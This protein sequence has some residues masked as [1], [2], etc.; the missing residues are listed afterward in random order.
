MK[1]LLKTCL[2]LLLFALILLFPQLSFQYAANGLNLWF[3]RMVPT[4]MPFMIL[5]T[6]MIRQNLS[7]TFVSLV[8]PLFGRIYK[9]NK[10]G[11]YCLFLGFLC[12]FP[13][14][15]RT[16]AELYEKQDIS[17]K[18]ATFLLAFCN[19]IGPVYYISFLLPNTELFEPAKLPFLLFGMYGIPL[20]YGFFLSRT[21]VALPQNKSNTSCKAQNPNSYHESF[22]L[23]LDTAMQGA[24]NG[25]TRLGG[26][27]ILCNLL[28]LFP[29]ALCLISGISV[30]EKTLAIINCILEITS[31]ISRMGASA[32]LFVLTLLPVGGISCLAQTASMLQ[33]TDLS[34]KNYLLHKC[35]QSLCA[36]IYY[37]LLRDF[38]F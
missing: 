7:Q 20:L 13:M 32:P 11:V 31:G 17:K 4:L 33:K 28:N 10:S 19:N 9:L 21:G 2:F 37:F 35:I 15:A 12:G 25:I 14:G 22:A 3:E 23:S 26:Y 34:M 1:K 8:N 16:V 27:M 24:V 29:H 38:L 30:S 6:L 5:S 36:F 18:E